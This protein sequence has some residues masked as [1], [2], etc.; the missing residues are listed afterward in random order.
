MYDLNLEH[1][2]LK[3]RS[4]GKGDLRFQSRSAWPD[5]N[6]I[7]RRCRGQRAA[8]GE[9]GETGDVGVGTGGGDVTMLTAIVVQDA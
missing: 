7:R 5:V 2:L 1:T 3:P 9:R 4:T 6:R 8:E